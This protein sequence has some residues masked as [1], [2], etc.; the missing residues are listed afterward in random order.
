MN[1]KH[2]YKML[3]EENKQLIR[4][5]LAFS[6][7]KLAVLES[8]VDDL[9]ECQDTDRE[10][11]EAKIKAL[12][13]RVGALEAKAHTHPYYF[14]SDGAYHM[15]IVSD[16]LDGSVTTVSTPY[17]LTNGDGPEEGAAVEK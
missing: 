9:A 7:S 10:E 12:E 15:T 14:S 16:S 8:S 3:R 1:Y 11:L 5:L 13:E 2:A 17:N 6:P 4:M